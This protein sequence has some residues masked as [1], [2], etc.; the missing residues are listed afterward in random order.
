[1]TIFW[2]NCGKMDKMVGSAQALQTWHTI[3]F[4]NSN[5]EYTQWHE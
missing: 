5:Q 4:S 3:E 2:Q 1:M